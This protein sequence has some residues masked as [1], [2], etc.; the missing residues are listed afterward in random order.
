MFDA[1]N[2]FLK[3]DRRSFTFDE[4]YRELEK[5]RWEHLHELPAEFATRDL[6]VIASQEK[7]L[8][9]EQGSIRVDLSRAA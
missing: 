5:I 2:A 4:F 8:S 3:L 1:R 9:E 6:F 7:W